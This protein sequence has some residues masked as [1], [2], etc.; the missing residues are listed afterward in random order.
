MTQHFALELDAL[1]ANAGWM[2]CCLMI[3]GQCHRLEATS[4]FPPFRDILTFARALATNQ[5]PY[6]FFW[7]EE[8]HGANFEA[9]PLT[10]ESP[11][12]HL[13]IDHDGEVVVDAEFERLEFAHQLLKALRQVALDCPGAESEWELP[14]FLVEDFEKQLAHGF[15]PEAKSEVSVAHFIFGHY[16]GYG[17]EVYPA[18]NLWVNDHHSLYMTMDDIP[19]FWWMWFEFLEKIGAGCLPAEAY[20]HKEAED[21]YDDHA[22][23]F[24]SLGIDTALRFQAQ[25]LPDPENFQLKIFSWK[26]PPNVEDAHVD[27]PFG[28]RQFVNSFSQAF[29]EFLETSYPAF[30]DSTE[31][32][33]DLRTLPIDRLLVV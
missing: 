12:F 10:P 27:A 26:S 33:F 21:L 6:D 7:E 31:N 24:I 5:L 17:G 25:A 8:G 9:L 18:F 11:N 13:K 20:F 28:R 16:G 30:L 14:Y 3:N 2:N 23:L 15:T 19:R 22:D 4:V 32:K 1:S 29:R